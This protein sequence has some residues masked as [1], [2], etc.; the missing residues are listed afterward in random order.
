MKTK[1]SSNYFQEFTIEH[2]KITD[3]ELVYLFNEQVGNSGWGITRQ[4][5]L[6]S[7]KEQLKKREIDYSSIGNKNTISYKYCIILRNK[8]LYLITELNKSEVESIFIEYF[9]CILPKKLKYNPKIMDYNF[10]ILRFGMKK[11]FGVLNMSCNKLIK[12]WQKV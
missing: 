1:T 10:E 2:N 3:L 9:K 11:H 7:I 4:G 6:Q 8:K 12:E 5:Y